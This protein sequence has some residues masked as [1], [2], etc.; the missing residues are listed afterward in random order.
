MSANKRPNLQLQY[1]RQLFQFR[2]GFYLE[3]EDNKIKP[4]MY[5]ISQSGDEVSEFIG[6]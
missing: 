4:E 1:T 5:F 2:F 6:G 3:N